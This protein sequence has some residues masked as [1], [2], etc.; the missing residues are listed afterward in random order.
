LRLRPWSTHLNGR[1]ELAGSMIQHIAQIFARMLAPDEV[2]RDALPWFG[3]DD[4]G[5]EHAGAFIRRLA[6]QMQH[7]HAG[8]VVVQHF[9]LRRLSDEFVTRGFD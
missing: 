7:A 2:Q 5:G 9:A 6:R 8:I 1:G 3:R 4:A